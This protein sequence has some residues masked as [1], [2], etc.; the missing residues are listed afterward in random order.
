MSAASRAIKR[1]LGRDFADS[2]TAHLAASLR[3]IFANRRIITGRGVINGRATTRSIVDC[4]GK[5]P[6]RESRRKSLANCR[7]DAALASRRYDDL[8]LRSI[9]SNDRF[10][11]ELNDRRIRSHVRVARPLQLHSFVRSFLRAALSVGTSVFM[12]LA[13][14]LARREAHSA[15]ARR[16]PTNSKLRGS[17]SSELQIPHAVGIF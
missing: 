8:S 1:N 9:G 16:P 6:A 3:A 5:I 4:Y 17:S 12:Q 13:R 14:P 11:T 10:G 2:R 15:I 7:A